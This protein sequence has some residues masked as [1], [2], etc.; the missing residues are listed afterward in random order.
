MPGSYTRLWERRKPWAIIFIV[1]SV[2][3]NEGGKIGRLRTATLNN[4]SRLWGRGA[5][6]G[7]LVPGPG[8]IRASV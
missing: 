3:R 4:F 7:C 2:E 5:V 8:A 6:P 1:V